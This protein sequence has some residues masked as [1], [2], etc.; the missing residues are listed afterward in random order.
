[1]YTEWYWKIDLHNLFHFLRLRMDGHAQQEIRDYAVIMAEMVRAVCPMAYEAFI[2]YTV[3]S[4]SF[5]A[6]EMKVLKEELN[7]FKTDKDDLVKKGLST[8]EAR[9]FSA[10]IKKLRKL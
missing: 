9:E 5:S 10:K 3:D 1:M 4:F 6:L 2:D 7:G 8:R